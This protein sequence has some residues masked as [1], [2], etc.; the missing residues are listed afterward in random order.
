M[1]AE[2]AAV[3]HRALRC[4]T[5]SNASSEVGRDLIFKLSLKYDK[6]ILPSVKL[7]GNQDLFYNVDIKVYEFK[8][9]REL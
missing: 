7:A 4:N 8:K 1:T 2:Q 6:I 9:T 3:K 5:P